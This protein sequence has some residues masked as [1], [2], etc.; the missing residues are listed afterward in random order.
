[1][2]DINSKILNNKIIHNG[3][4]VCFVLVVII[5][6]L[7]KV[8]FYVKVFN[9]FVVTYIT[10]LFNMFVDNNPPRYARI[11]DMIAKDTDYEECG[12]DYLEEVTVLLNRTLHS[13][14]VIKKI[15]ENENGGKEKI[16]YVINE[17][18]SNKKMIESLEVPL[19]YEE[20]QEEILNNLNDFI[21]LYAKNYNV[22]T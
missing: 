2:K 7:M 9:V 12:A 18:I 15:N 20:K 19:K 11:L 14:S 21:S 3:I 6:F 1:M 5:L 17:I 10:L 4:Y 16:V 8:P 22:Y 13:I